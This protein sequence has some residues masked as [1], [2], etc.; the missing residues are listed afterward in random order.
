MAIAVMTLGCAS[1][2]DRWS[3]RLGGEIPN[4]RLPSTGDCDNDGL[5][6]SVWYEYDNIDANA[7][8]TYTLD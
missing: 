7:G 3:R 5:I 6:L 1:G 4:I 2:F 8:T